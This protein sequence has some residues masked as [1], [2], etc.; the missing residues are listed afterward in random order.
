MESVKEKE[1][2]I[3]LNN[4]KLYINRELSWLEFNRRV[5]EEAEDLN[6][7]LLERLK[8]IAIFFTNLDEFF[9]IR[10]AGLKQMVSANI[11]KPSFDGL[12]PKEQLKRITQKTKQLLKETELQY[13]KLT[14]EL[15]KES[16]YIHK[17]SELPKNLKKKADKYFEEFVY[18]VLTPLAVDLTHPFPHLP[19]LSFNIIVEMI[20]EDLKFG[21]IPIPK[22]LPR[23]IRLKEK[24]KEEHY[25][26]LEDLIIHHIRKLFPNQEIRSIATFRVTRDADIIIQ[27]D[28]A[29]DLLEEIEKG[30]RKRRFGKPVRLEINGGSEFIF[31]FLKDELEIK[32]YDI[33]K[34]E[35]PLNLS[36]LWSLYKEI[37][38][39]DLKFP[40]YVPYYP[41]QFNIDIFNALKSHE[42][43]LFPPY[44]SFDP[45]VELIEEAAEDPNVLAI[46]QTL[47]R[48]GR[49]SPIVEALSKAAQ[50]GKE[51]TAVVEIKARF[52][53]ESNIVWAKRLEEEGVHVIYGIPGLKTHAKLLM[54]VRREENG[55]KR[56]VHLGTGNYNVETAKIYSDISYLTSLPG[57][58]ED[59][60][61]IFNV[62]TGYF[63]PPNLSKLFISPVNLKSK[64]LEM[65]EEEATLGKEGRIIAKMNSLVDPDVIRALYKASQEGVKI[66]LIVRGICCLRPGIKGVSENIRVIS[67]VGKY[68]E[69]ARIFYFKADGEEKIFISSADWMPRNFHRR[70]ETLVP[71]ENF[72]LKRKLRDILE[73][74]LRDT[75]KAR[76]LMPDGSY[77]RP[78]ERNFNSQE[79]FEKWVRQ[80]K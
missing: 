75:A 47:Y 70:I 37:D 25:L 71:I 57:I 8:F 63:H 39:P 79:Y 40:P 28:E 15:K 53:E 23:F 13:K 42:F 62:L 30:L 55:I 38:R 9:M 29:D 2:G 34:L 56:Y 49:N 22:V 3:N 67:I 78:K 68:L 54:I 36:D 52:D 61:K 66:D 21:V 20:S 26:Y 73:I 69:H 19:S 65:I 14:S 44:E 35:V 18:P 60:S 74:Q 24:E 33:Y 32:D 51:V 12:T 45:I 1:K 4:P 58:G 77:I 48:V 76:I 7:P 50:K 10:V 6:N 72:Q 41:P 64:I 59:V 5:L 11:N 31:N 27:E 46:K 80:I 43:I 16:I 17:Y